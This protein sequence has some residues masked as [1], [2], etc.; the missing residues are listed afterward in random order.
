MS[1]G[2]VMDESTVGAPAGAP[3]EPPRTGE[4]IGRYTIEGILGTG[5]MGVVFAARDPDLD[6]RVAVKILR[7]ASGRDQSQARPRL[8]REA[9]AMAKLSHPNVI[10]VHE[11]G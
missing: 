5:G 3:G 7:G 11:V 1:A 2:D 8:L 10:T 6:R 4:R 9:R